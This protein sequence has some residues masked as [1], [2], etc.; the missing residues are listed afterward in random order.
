M[1]VFSP[2]ESRRFL[3]AA[4]KDPLSAMCAVVVTAGLRSNGNFGLQKSDLNMKAGT[5]CARR[6]RHSEGAHSNLGKVAE[7]R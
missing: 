7:R 3:G 2:E 4:Q 6:T 5:L 1:Q